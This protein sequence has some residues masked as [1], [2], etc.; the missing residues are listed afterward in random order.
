MPCLDQSATRAP[1]SIK[2]SGSRAIW[3][4]ADPGP[5]L[6]RPTSWRPW[7]NAHVVQ[8]HA[9]ASTIC[10]FEPDRRIVHRIARDMSRR[11]VAASTPCRR[12]QRSSSRAEP[13]ISSRRS[14]PRRRWRQKPHSRQE[15]DILL[16]VDCVAHRRGDDAQAGVE[17]PT[18]APRGG[19]VGR[20]IAIRGALEDQIARG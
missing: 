20:E 11:R 7:Q 9:R 4:P 12:G 6:P 19:V 15:R 10:R 17:A 14:S 1:R 3:T 2:L 18:A 13:P 16:A 8:E 5:A